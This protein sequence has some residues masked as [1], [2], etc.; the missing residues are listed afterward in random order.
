MVEGIS[1]FE[2]KYTGHVF[3]LYWELIVDKTPSR[4][5]IFHLSRFPILSRELQLSNNAKILK[6]KNSFDDEL[7]SQ[8]TSIIS[9]AKVFI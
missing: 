9:T 7:L 6:E 1:I 3:H 5:C 8:M 4:F 2:Q